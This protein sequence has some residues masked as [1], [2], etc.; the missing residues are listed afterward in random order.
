MTTYAVKS[1]D[2]CG[3]TLALTGAVRN[4]RV[5]YPEFSFVYV[6]NPYYKPLLDENEDF[7]PSGFGKRL[8][9]ICYGTGE[10]RADRGTII[11]ANTKTLCEYIGIDNVPITCTT[12]HVVLTQGEINWGKR[13]EGKWLL[14]ANCQTCSINKGYPHWQGVVDCM[15]DLGLDVVQVGGRER[16]DLSTDLNGVED[17]RGKTNLR[18][19]LS[20]VYNCAGIVSP[21]SG[22]IHAGAIWGVPMVCVTGAR[23]HTGI[24]AYPTVR[25]VTSECD[26]QYCMN[27][28]CKHYDGKWCECMSS[29]EPERIA[30]LCL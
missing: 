22:I 15:H 5:C 4:V 11:E 12:A 26:N 8:K 29:I 7:I 13:F 3:D 6:G 20:M 17:W 16:R 2:Q 19:W 23:E 28:G 21:P 27:D 10:K 30:T 9:P 18:E 25:H 14:N 24:T 1:W